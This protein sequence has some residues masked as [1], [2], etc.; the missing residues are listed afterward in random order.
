MTEDEKR[1][2][3]RELLEFRDHIRK[4]RFYHSLT[5]QKQCKQKSMVNWYFV[6]IKTKVLLEFY[7]VSTN[8]TQI[9]M[10]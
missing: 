1:E 9:R 6:L 8:G 3:L 10:A 5:F 2:F 7:A 4:A